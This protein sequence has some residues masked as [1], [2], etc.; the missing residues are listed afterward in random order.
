MLLINAQDPGRR[1]IEVERATK[2]A[3]FYALAH[4]DGQDTQDPPNVQNL[5]PA[6]TRNRAAAVTALMNRLWRIKWDNS[7]K[8]PFWTFIYNGIRTAARTYTGPRAALAPTCGCGAPR[9]D[10]L[11]HFWFCPVAD[12]I[13]NVLSD[14]VNTQITREHLFFALP[15]PGVHR[16][17]W[18][19]A[20]LAAISVL[21]RS[22]FALTPTRRRRAEPFDAIL[23]SVTQRFWSHLD[24]FCFVG[25]ST[26]TDPWLATLPQDHPLLYLPPGATR[27]AARV[28]QGEEHI[29]DP[30]GPAAGHPAH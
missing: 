7:H 30:A 9:P 23:A 20:C 10:R 15:P 1:S 14:A 6:A 19:A 25:P 22:F 27:L 3:E 5:P 16:Y 4:A 28:P 26:A 24:D 18:S 13:R 11:H 2:L 21:H 12:T 29:A 17:V 8:E